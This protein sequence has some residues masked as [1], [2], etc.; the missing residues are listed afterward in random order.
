MPAEYARLKDI[1]QWL[2][3]KEVM[4]YFAIRAYTR[5]RKLTRL[6]YGRETGFHA[7]HAYAANISMINVI[8]GT[9][10]PMI[11]SLKD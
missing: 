3:K 4:Q 11:R 8:D 5:S 9:A 6:R 7:V 10:R 1:D 2:Q